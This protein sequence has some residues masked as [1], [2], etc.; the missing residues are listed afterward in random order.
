MTI[1]FVS[2]HLDVTPEEFNEFYKSQIDRALEDTGSSFVVGDARGADYLAMQYLQGRTQSVTV[3]TIL[4]SKHEAVSGVMRN[5]TRP[6]RER[7]RVLFK[8]SHQRALNKS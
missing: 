8:D 5:A 1:Y 2:G 4:V 3:Y 6:S 7:L